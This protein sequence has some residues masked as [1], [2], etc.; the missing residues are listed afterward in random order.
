MVDRDGERDD[1]TELLRRA[2]QGDKQ[3][4]QDLYSAVAQHLRRLAGYHV[5]GERK[6][7]S[8]Q[9][10]DLFH[11]AFGRLKLGSIQWQS[12]RDYYRVMSTVMKHALIDKAK[13][14][15]HKRELIRVELCEWDAVDNTD[16]DTVLLVADL[17]EQLEKTKPQVARAIEMRFYAG[18]QVKD[19]AGILR[20][21]RR[22][23]TR[24]L[25]EGVELLREF[26]G[27]QGPPPDNLLDD[28]PDDPPDDAP[29]NPRT[30]PPDDFPPAGAAALVPKNPPLAPLR[31]AHA[32]T[33]S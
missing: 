33:S 16:C 27:V 29:D 13:K 19:I 2:S 10:T 14:E 26:A 1:I 20:V 22:T 8:W 12:R 7:C 21:D 9:A 5:R 30:D 3:A 4:E 28:P 25:R 15:K 24:H 32:L 11:E 18:F 31:S 6:D 17:V 23:V